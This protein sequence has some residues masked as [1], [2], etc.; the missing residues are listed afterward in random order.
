MSL[1]V[2]CATKV[3]VARRSKLKWLNQSNMHTILVY[4]QCSLY[5]SKATD[6]VIKV[7]HRTD[8]HTDRSKSISP[9]ILCCDINATDIYICGNRWNGEL[10]S[11]T[12][13]RPTCWLDCQNICTKFLWLTDWLTDC[14]P[15]CQPV[16]PTTGPIP[17]RP[18]PSKTWIYARLMTLPPELKARPSP[19]P[20]QPLHPCL[21]ASAINETHSPTPQ[22]PHP[23]PTISCH[24][25]WMPHFVWLLSINGFS[26]TLLE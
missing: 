7:D 10:M 21:P 18:S 11:W 5:S 1:T 13:S 17:T 16:Y 15:A 14:L 24:N 9:I 25:G 20:P 8:R 3:K 2:S 22:S 12:Q 6:V 19:Y 4:G 23:D 26:E